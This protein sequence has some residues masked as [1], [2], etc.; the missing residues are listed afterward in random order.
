M[1]VREGDICN[2]FGP[3]G[4]GREG[5]RKNLGGECGHTPHEG[6]KPPLS[7]PPKLVRPVPSDGRH[8]G[9]LEDTRGNE[10]LSTDNHI[11]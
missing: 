2:A 5:P 6:A 11:H 10:C 7:S 3:C 8:S 9:V 1:H 4:R